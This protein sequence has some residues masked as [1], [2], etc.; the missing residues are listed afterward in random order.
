LRDLNPHL[1]CPLCNGYFR[2]AYT[3]PEC[4][5]TFCKSCLY[6]HFHAGGSE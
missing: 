3:I 4:M 2:D 6:K 1:V 5:D